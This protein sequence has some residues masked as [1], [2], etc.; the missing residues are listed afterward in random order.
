MI[1]PWA[2]DAH[3]DKGWWAEV[4]RLDTLCSNSGSRWEY[5]P[6]GCHQVPSVDG[7]HFSI[8]GAEPLLKRLGAALIKF[9]N[10]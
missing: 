8:E 10:E 2:N 6:V 1:G 3:A 7:R 5:L 9:Y 4:Q